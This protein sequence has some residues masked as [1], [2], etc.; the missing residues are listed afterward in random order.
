MID[1]HTPQTMAMQQLQG[2]GNAPANNTD[3]EIWRG[4]DDGN[5]SY[6]ADSIHVTEGG[7]IGINCGGHV[8]VR[9]LRDWHKQ[10]ARIE[11]LEAALRKIAEWPPSSRVDDIINAFI[12]AKLFAR[13]ALAPEPDADG[14]IVMLTRIEALE[15]EC[16]GLAANQ[17]N[18]GYGDEYGHFRCLRIEA[19]EAALREIANWPPS[20]EYARNLALAALAEG[21]DK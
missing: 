8:I 17:C 16:F 10:A 3:R 4:P 19:L 11:A 15:K 6:Y 13:K 7:G 9:P 2:S 20:T 18:H 21:Q 12:D 5:G 14:R 1:D